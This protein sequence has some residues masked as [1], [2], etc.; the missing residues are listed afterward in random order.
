MQAAVEKGFA[1]ETGMMYSTYRAWVSLVMKLGSVFSFLNLSK[2]SRL[3]SPKRAHII[4][5]WY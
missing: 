1:R 2:E 4:D 5:Q 3:L